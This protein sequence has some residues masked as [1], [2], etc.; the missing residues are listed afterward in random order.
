MFCSFSATCVI[1]SSFKYVIQKKNEQNI[2]RFSGSPLVNT[3]GLVAW[4]RGV[5]VITS[6]LHAEGPRFDPGRNQL[7]FRSF[8]YI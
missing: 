3:T 2:F 4:F 7:F 8:F 5:A 6:A 1:N